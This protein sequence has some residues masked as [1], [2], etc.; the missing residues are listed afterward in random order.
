MSDW[1]ESYEFGYIPILNDITCLVRLINNL[2]T[3]TISEKVYFII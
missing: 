1:S 3:F 2:V